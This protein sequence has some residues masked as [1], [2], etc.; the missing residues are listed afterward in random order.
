[1]EEDNVQLLNVLGTPQPEKAILFDEEILESEQK[2][3]IDLSRLLDIRRVNNPEE[4]INSLYSRTEKDIV[5]GLGSDYMDQELNSYA[6]KQQIG[7]M[8]ELS[9]AWAGQDVQFSSIADSVQHI[10]DVKDFYTDTDGF[11]QAM[12]S[13]QVPTGIEDT[14][15]QRK[16][17]QNNA[18]MMVADLAE[19]DGTL[20]TVW[21]AVGLLAPDYLKDISDTTD[22]SMAF[23]GGSWVEYAEKFKL[24]TPDEQNILVQS[25]IPALHKHFEGN[26]FKVMARVEELFSPYNAANSN[27]FNLL[28]DATAVGDVVVGMKAMRALKGLGSPAKR[29][30]DNEAIEDAARLQTLPA[31]GNPAVEKA[32]GVSKVDAAHSMNP[33]GTAVMDQGTSIDNIAGEMQLVQNRVD[34]VVRTESLPPYENL[35]GDDAFK[36]LKHQEVELEKATI[37]LEKQR[38]TVFLSEGDARRKISQIKADLADKTISET[39]RKTLQEDLAKLEAS[40]TKLESL[41]SSLKLVREKLE[42]LK[43]PKIREVG[44]ET[45]K[46]VD[47]AEA[48]RMK[49]TLEK[50][51]AEIQKAIKEFKFE[52]GRLADEK[53]SRGEVKALVKERDSLQVKLK[54]LKAKRDAVPSTAKGSAKVQQGYKAER[55]AL[56]DQIEDVRSRI[57]RLSR[58][59]DSTRASVEAEGNLSRMEQG[60]IP[61]KLQSELDAIRQ[62]IKAAKIPET[63]KQAKT[64]QIAQGVIPKEM[65]EA[66]KVEAAKQAAKIQEEA[67]AVQAPSPL[68]PV[69]E[70][71]AVIPKAAVAAEKIRDLMKAIIRPPLLSPEEA[72]L[73]EKRAVEKLQAQLSKSGT[74]VNAIEIVGKD[75]NSITMK[76]KTASGEGEHT[77][78]IT[79]D[80]VGSTVSENV[81]PDFKQSWMNTVGGKIFSQESLLSVLNKEIVGD[82]TFAGQQS[83][84]IKNRIS[85]LWRDAEAGLSK[86]ELFQVD[87]V[88]RMGDE[89]GLETGIEQFTVAQLRS[90]SLETAA[91]RFKLSNAQIECYYIKRAMYRELHSVMDNII[92]QR[93]EFEGFENLK[94]VENGVSKDL[95]GRKLKNFDVSGIK[96][97]EAIYFPGDP[98]RT[99]KTTKGDILVQ[100]DKLKE[101]G[102]TVVEL[103]EPKRFSDGREANFA[104][105]KDD[106]AEWSR[107]PSKVLNYSPGYIPRIYR[108]GYYFVRNTASEANE[109]LYAFETKAEAEKWTREYIQNGGKATVY[110][111]GEFGKIGRAL[112]DAR[113]FGGLYTGPRKQQPLLVKTPTGE[114]KLERMSVGQATERYINNIAKVMP[115]NEYRM[116]AVQRWENDVGNLADA[117]G[118]SGLGREQK[119]DTPDD[120]VDLPEETKKLM[121]QTRE[122]I[123]EVMGV[124]PQEERITETIALSAANLMYGKPY[125]SKPRDWLLNN[126]KGS[127]TSWIKGHT[128]DLRLG[129]FNP[130]QIFVQAQNGALAMM[131]EPKHALPALG[132]AIEL[133]TIALLPM[134]KAIEAAKH[135]RL[136]QDVVDSLLQYNKS[137]LK[138]AISHNA[139]LDVHQLGVAHNSMDVIRKARKAGR[140]FYEEG[141]NIAR[142]ISWSIARRKWKEANPSKV[143]GDKDIYD[144]SKEATSM[145][146]NMQ[147]QNAAWW[148]KGAMG[149]PTQFMQVQ[150]KI[151]E[152]LMPRVLGGNSKWTRQQKLQ[153]LAGQLMLYGVVGVPIVEEAASYVASLTGQT[154]QEFIDNNPEWVNAINEGFMGVMVSSIGGQDINMSESMSLLAGMDEM[155]PIELAKAINAHAN[156]GMEETGFVETMSGPTATTIK[157]LGDLAS[158]T[159]LNLKAVVEVPTLDVAYGAILSNLESIASLTSTW[160]NA[161]K[162]YYLNQFGL[163][164]SSN[165]KLIATEKELGPMSLTSQLGIAMG[166]KSDA[167][168]ALFS[169]KEALRNSKEFKKKIETS[170]SKALENYVV[171]GNQELYDAQKAVLMAPLPPTQRIDVMDKIV[172]KKWKSISALEQN[173]K[174]TMTHLINTG[175][176]P[177]QAQQTVISGNEQ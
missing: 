152:N 163:L 160:S 12:I 108:P 156:G 6:T 177:T 92:R 121:L 169:S 3:R 97:G 109:V 95:I 56:N 24:R 157:R 71:G 45:Q 46:V 148:Q 54:E 9:A 26:T 116:A 101:Q 80:D 112:E 161:E 44:K 28:M 63:V 59:L 39:R 19:K 155:L 100:K 88:L 133:R 15:A 159:Y 20:D 4:D 98:I 74:E 122:Y 79:R 23:L 167:E 172:E 149:L 165:G 114:T 35:I 147:S 117:K 77:Y 50:E 173:R 42:A 16:A 84:V 123:K 134:D 73:A 144:I 21:N 51:E 103:V 29:A 131:L 36:A 70:V 25:L 113:A 138:D 132:S 111:D 89:E 64:S 30:V 62:S 11:E 40:S 52:Q 82:T 104:L 151:I 5:N 129:W 33:H 105:V 175:E 162:G 14:R 168:I 31:S 176:N 140:V 150:M 72:A 66:V 58:Q 1:M 38:S 65:Q 137:G 146:M 128:F 115:I 135:M 130:R 85:E 120:E 171:T 90:G 107:L 75:Y 142:L 145:L 81:A 96:D 83:A 41:N 22:E 141:E 18:M 118:R 68:P 67:K 53:P 153:V 69:A 87:A 7:L 78:R 170:L 27:V 34:E 43:T 126:S 49:A 47:E 8:D 55:V 93:L 60:I 2:K 37:L 166:F 158:T 17:V 127:V 154:P 61:A 139:D 125:L 94:Y 99:K 174:E 10:Q 119:F 102:Y 143:I 136:N 106:T 86:E 32:T 48:Y 124:A 110:R 164:V 13:A 91:G 76:Y 57:A